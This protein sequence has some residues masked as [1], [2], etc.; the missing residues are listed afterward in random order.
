MNA[1]SSITLWVDPNVTSRMDARCPCKFRY[2]A[3]CAVQIEDDGAI[4]GSAGTDLGDVELTCAMNARNPQGTCK[5]R[6]RRW[7]PGGRDPGG[8]QS[9]VSSSTSETATP[10]SAI[11]EPYAITRGTCDIGVGTS[12][13]LAGKLVQAALE[14]PVC[15]LADVALAID[16]LSADMQS[17]LAFFRGRV[18]LAQAEISKG[19]ERKPSLPPGERPPG[20]HGVIYPGSPY[21]S[22]HSL[23]LSRPLFRGHTHLSPSNRHQRKS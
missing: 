13:V 12:V 11:R 10:G 1:V 15:I 23:R 20:L 14:A 3:A 22:A 17:S 4:T 16:G 2:C 8:S 18:E 6:A 21:M 9:D 19:R 7:W 5:V